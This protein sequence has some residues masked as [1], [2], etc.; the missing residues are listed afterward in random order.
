MLAVIYVF[1]TVSILFAI[2]TLGYVVYDKVI[3][4]RD[5]KLVAMAKAPLLEELSHENVEVEE[6]ETEM[7]IPSVDSIDAIEADEL[8][9]D[10]TAMKSVEKEKGAGHGNKGTVNIGDID[11][12]FESSD[13]VT[14]ELLKEKELLHKNV[15]RVKI[16]AD[17]I[18]TKPLTVKAESFSVQAIKMIKLTGGN[19]IVLD[20]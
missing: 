17:G 1:I 6:E 10:T 13:V 9:S 16:L 20:D 18:L 8:L 7:I 12:A 2:S 4:E 15:G 5:H 3:E 14:I 11:K 19:V